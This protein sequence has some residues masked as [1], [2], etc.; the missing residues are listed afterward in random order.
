MEQSKNSWPFGVTSW[1][2]TVKFAQLLFGVDV[3]IENYAHRLPY[4]STK[5]FL[6][7]AKGAC[8]RGKPFSEI[9]T[10]IPAQLAELEAW[11]QMT[12]GNHMRPQKS[13]QML[14]SLGT[15]YYFS[16][17]A[18]RAPCIC[19]TG[20]GADAHHKHVPTSSTSWDSAGSFAK[21]WDATLLRNYSAFKNRDLR[22][23]WLEKSWQVLWNWNDHN[24][25]HHIDPHSD[26]APTY[27]PQDPITSL[28]FGHGGVLTL[29]SLNKKKP[30]QPKMLFQEGG[31]V[32]IMAGDFQAEFQ[33][34]VPARKD[35]AMLMQQPMFATLAEWEKAGMRHEIALHENAVPGVPHVRMNCTIRW[36][37]THIYGCP[38]HTDARTRLLTGALQ[39]PAAFPPLTAASVAAPAAASTQRFQPLFSGD[40]QVPAK[41]PPW[42]VTAPGA[43]GTHGT[44]PVLT[45]AVQGDPA[46][47]MVQGLVGVKKRAA[48][49][50]ESKPSVSKTP[51]SEK[52]ELLQERSDKLITQLLDCIAACL[53]QNDMF[54]MA[55][56]G[57]PLVQALP[58][59]A[60]MLAKIEEHVQ[61][62]RSSLREASEAVQEFSQS[63]ADRVSFSSLNLMGLAA[64]QRRDIQVQL[65][66]FQTKEGTSWIIQTQVKATQNCLNKE[67]QFRKC[68]LSHRQLEL[69]LENLSATEMQTHREIAFDLRGLPRGLFPSSLT[70]A[71]RHPRQAKQHQN[72]NFGE[73][74]YDLDD[75]R[76]L[77]LK[78]LEVGYVKDLEKATR[79]QTNTN[80]FGSMKKPIAETVDSLKSGLLT[81]LQHLRTMDSAK[82]SF[83][84]RTDEEFASENYDIWVWLAK[85]RP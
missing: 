48:V 52:S 44:Q 29:S 24:K 31:D 43:A 51:R 32:L 63:H 21:L 67:M 42:H 16:A 8:A 61:E 54:A 66:K 4:V 38:M 40:V 14:G 17:Q 55:I 57:T 59:H 85:V 84:D 83:R 25:G 69:L 35:W 37:H 13:Q 30:S 75:A 62:L 46:A 3:K 27:S 10:L 73:E 56:A 5:S 11:E 36:H 28:S 2:D 34:G 65:G 39:P 77:L 7:F 58:V 70:C 6:L 71:V 45:G 41:A 79:L 33:H 1:E 60:E 47:R 23:L 78:A 53:K 81:L 22:P 80:S 20:F 19:R 12:R 76:V 64:R 26:A 9:A 82:G 50:E 72:E 74:P 18:T 68:L 49:E 15:V